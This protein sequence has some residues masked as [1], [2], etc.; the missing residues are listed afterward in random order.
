MCRLR[1]LNRPIH[2][3]MIR[4]RIRSPFR[5]VCLIAAICFLAATSN[6]FAEPAVER[7]SFTPR[8]DGEGYVVRFHLDGAVP[9][10]SE[11]REIGGGQLEMI[12]FNTT[13]ARGFD[14]GTAE[15]PVS[16]YSGE[17]A[18]GHLVFRFTLRQETHVTASAY[19]DRN[20]NDILLGLTYGEPPVRTAVADARESFQ[21]PVKPAAAT[22]SM[23]PRRSEA[24]PRR[25]ENASSEAK[26]WM[27]DTIV[28]D[29]GHGG[30][31][32]GAVANGLREKD[33]TLRVARKLG[34]HIE[35]KLG[36]DVVFTRD[37]DRFIALKDRGKI[38]NA[39]GGKLFISLHVNSARSAQ[40]HGTETYFIGLHKSE[41][42]RS[43]MERENSVIHLE[44]NPEQ[45]K[46]M[47]EG[48]LIRME[49]TQSAYMRKSEELSSLIEDQFSDRVG[50]KSR[51]VKQAGF[52][53][54]WGASM[55]AILVELG[56]LTNRNEARFLSSEEGQEYMASAIFRAVRAYK[57]QYEKGLTYIAD[58]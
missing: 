30:H 54:L 52:Y 13:L 34:S 19:R 2:G 41:A 29:A 38:A 57:N 32:P 42:A 33:I 23:K 14:H 56:F 20:S 3:I 47:N 27:L 53:V 21:V 31:D 40:A 37:D 1:V 49:L 50:R 36:I 22:G 6:A 15:G 55:P 17:P 8:S 39:K 45:Y 58:E 25:T 35:E 16:S 28:I 48:A 5:I 18:G 7:V 4:H 46:N 12:L 11:P 24:P 43:T 10:Y 51:G 26:R 9:A 44:S